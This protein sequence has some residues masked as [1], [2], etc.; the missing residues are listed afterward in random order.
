[1]LNSRRMSQPEKAGGE[2]DQKAKK[3]AGEFHAVDYKR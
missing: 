3:D 1:M 2:A